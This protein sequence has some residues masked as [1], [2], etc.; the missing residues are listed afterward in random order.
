MSYWSIVRYCTTKRG[1]KVLKNKNSFI[2]VILGVPV[3]YVTTYIILKNTHVADVKLMGELL[4]GYPLFTFIA[5]IVMQ[6]LIKKKVI[7]LSIIFIGYLF[8]TL[9][10]LVISDSSGLIYGFINTFTKKS[11]QKV[12]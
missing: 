4:I 2:K 7:V 8:L 12:Q 3:I 9:V 6:L 5:S 1:G 10:S 11:C